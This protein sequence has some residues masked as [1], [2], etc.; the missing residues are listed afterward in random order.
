M[1]SERR[2]A[3]RAEP[4]PEP[5]A[6]ELEQQRDQRRLERRALL[7]GALG[8]GGA[9]A[10]AGLMPSTIFWSSARFTS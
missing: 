3:G 7:K 2:R 1:S 10:A 9:A 6:Q 8:L 5:S 4:A